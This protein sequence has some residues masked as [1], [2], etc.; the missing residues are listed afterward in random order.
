MLMVKLIVMGKPLSNTSLG[1]AT[2]VSLAEIILGLVVQRVISIL[3]GLVFYIHRSIFPSLGA[4][5]S[6]CSYKR[7]NFHENQEPLLVLSIYRQAQSTDDQVKM[8]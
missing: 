6:N 1:T 2:F 3:T 7:E 4:T 8:I 5:Q